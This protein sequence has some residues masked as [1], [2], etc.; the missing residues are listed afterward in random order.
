MAD[1]DHYGSEPPQMTSVDLPNHC[2]I[3]FDGLKQETDNSNQIETVHEGKKSNKISLQGHDK[4]NQIRKDSFKYNICDKTLLSRGSLKTHTDRVHARKKLNKISCDFCDATFRFESLLKTHIAAV[5]DGK[6]PY[7]CEIC[8]FS[9]ARNSDLIQHISRVHEGQ[10]PFT[11]E[12]C[13]KSFKTKGDL[14]S[15]VANI[16]ERRKSFHCEI[17]S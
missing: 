15:H 14:K 17:C 5:H 4:E 7:K 6:K 1:P 11:C 8:S 2:E 3:S 10:R 13:D 9:S 12:T 16:H